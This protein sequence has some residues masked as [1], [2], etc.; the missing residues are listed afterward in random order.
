MSLTNC[1]THVPVVRPTYIILT[2]A[3]HWPSL[4]PSA[5]LTSLVPKH[6][7]PASNLTDKKPVLASFIPRAALCP[8]PP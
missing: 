5:L 7:A 2:R 8:S 6:S 4:C 3:P 1:L